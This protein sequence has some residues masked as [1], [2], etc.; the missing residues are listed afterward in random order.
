MCIN[1]PH[2]PYLL[3]VEMGC[4]GC[5][6]PKRMGRDTR[7]PQQGD[8]CQVSP[9][10]RTHF[11][12][13]SQLTPP[14]C[15]TPSL[16]P[17]ARR[18]GVSVLFVW[19]YSL[20]RSKRETEGGICSFLWQHPLPRSKRETEGSPYVSSTSTQPASYCSQGEM[21]VLTE[22]TDDNDDVAPLPRHQHPPLPRQPQHQPNDDNDDV[23]PLPRHQRPPLPRQPQHQPNDDNDDV[24]PL[25]RHQRPPLPRQPNNDNDVAPLPR[26]QC[27]PPTPI[28]TTAA[29]PPLL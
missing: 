11:R 12:A 27:P 26:H 3:P 21:G 16:A 1:K 5:R 20:P 18:R 6:S 13:T 24:A 10:S 25:P 23:A 15:D 19:Q 9:P 28:T 22:R 7:R 4:E 29:P 17:N 14:R 2:P 8:T